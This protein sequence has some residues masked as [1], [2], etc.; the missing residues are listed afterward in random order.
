[1][2]VILE[3]LILF[4]PLIWEAVSDWYRIEIQKKEDNHTEDVYVRIA[5]CI[6]VGFLLRFTKDGANVIAAAIYSGSLFIALFDPILNGLRKKPFFY[7]GGNPT[8]KFILN[9]LPRHAEV[10]MRLWVP[11]VGW[12]VYYKWNVLMGKETWW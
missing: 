7:K 11:F 12:C 8:D 2:N 5:L 6:V 9:H 10:F 4:I 1:M 3:Y